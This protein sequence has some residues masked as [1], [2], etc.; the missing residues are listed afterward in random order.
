MNR[1]TILLF[2]IPL[3]LN[4]KETVKE[5]TGQKQVYGNTT[6]YTKL[7]DEKIDYSQTYEVSFNL[8]KPADCLTIDIE[9][10]YLHKTF[11]VQKVPK[12][13]LFYL[14][15]KLDVTKFKMLT[16]KN[17]TQLG[18]NFNNDW[19][20]FSPVKICG[21]KDDPLSTLDTSEYRIRFT[22][23]EEKQLYYIITII[24]ESKIIFIDYTPSLKK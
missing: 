4:C 8:D 12:R 9:S 1:F 20:I 19:D 11:P 10:A 22:A 3:F 2:L 7:S 21:K 17:Y 18:R 16:G 24:C 15:K 5:D 23:F 13:T 14:E 6:E